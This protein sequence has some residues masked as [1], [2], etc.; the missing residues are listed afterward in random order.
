ME[1]LTP[2]PSTILFY[3]GVCHFC[4]GT[5]QFILRNDKKQKFRFCALQSELGKQIL[6]KHGFTTDSMDTIVMLHQGTILTEST[7]VLTTLKILGGLFGL[8]YGFMV[9]PKFIRD[10]FYRLIARNRY[11]LFGKKEACRIP[12]A[13][14]KA[15][16]LGF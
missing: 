9:V 16:F 15:Q 11:R 12:D 4:D 13:S 6:E 10:A 8:A 1:K 5:V 14:Q 3:D 7:A 2:F